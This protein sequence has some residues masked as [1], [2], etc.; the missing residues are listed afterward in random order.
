MW[1][2]AFNISMLCK[3]N[4]IVSCPDEDLVGELMNLLAGQGVKWYGLRE[5]PSKSS[6]KWEDYGKDTCYW[7]ED[8]RL[9]YANMEYAVKNAREF[10]DHIKCTFYG[11][12]PD[13]EISETDFE[14]IISAGR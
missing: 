10:S 7:I 13:I 12:E 8:G 11:T 2:T 6:S 3:Q 4:V 9:T 5:T 14:A 1:E